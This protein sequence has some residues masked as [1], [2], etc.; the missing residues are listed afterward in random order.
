VTP[1]PWRDEDGAL[2]FQL[3]R[4]FRSL[5]SILSWMDCRLLN[6]PTSNFAAIEAL[7]IGGDRTSPGEQR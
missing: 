6:S 4:R 1:K 3:G 7:G 5:Q 2:V